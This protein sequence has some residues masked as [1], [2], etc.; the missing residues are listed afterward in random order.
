METT[1]IYDKPF[2]TIDEL[3]E[4]LEWRYV[5]ITDRDFAKH[6]ILDI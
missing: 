3:L 2:R 5:V 4:L 1:I 6:C